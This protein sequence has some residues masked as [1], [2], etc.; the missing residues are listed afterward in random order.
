MAYIP[1]AP[2][3]SH[4]LLR[5]RADDVVRSG[6]VRLLTNGL[7]VARSVERKAQAPVRF[8]VVRRQP[9]RC[10]RFGDHVLIVKPCDALR[11]VGTMR[12]AVSSCILLWPFDQTWF[13]WSNVLFQSRA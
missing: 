4:P 10:S 8:G 7:A 12:T 3:A 2:L 11:I 9:N 1:P 5:A 6:V 13:R